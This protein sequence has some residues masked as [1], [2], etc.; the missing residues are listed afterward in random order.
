MNIEIIIYVFTSIFVV[1]G[2]IVAIW[3]FID[4]HRIRSAKDYHQTQENKKETA[5]RRYKEKNRLGK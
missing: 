1:L 3:S 5:Q 2:L 4:T